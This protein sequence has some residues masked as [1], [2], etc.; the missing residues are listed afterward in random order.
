MVFQYPQRNNAAPSAW[1]FGVLDVRITEIICVPVPVL[2][3]GAVKIRPQYTTAKPQCKG[4]ID[5]FLI[6]YKNFSDRVQKVT[7]PE[8]QCEEKG[9]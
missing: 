7:L 3:C 9:I 5:P 2:R 1:N 8:V 4:K 6:I